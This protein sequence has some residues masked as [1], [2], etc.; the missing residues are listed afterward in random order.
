[1]HDGQLSA[2]KAHK[3]HSRCAGHLRLVLLCSSGK[4]AAKLGLAR[5][6]MLAVAVGCGGNCVDS[7]RIRHWAARGSVWPP[8]F[9]SEVVVGAPHACAGHAAACTIVN[10]WHRI[11]VVPVASH[12]MA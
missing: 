1:M 11:S 3:E 4:A 12:T 8:E 5:M 2:V 6:M 7:N 9:A 10:A